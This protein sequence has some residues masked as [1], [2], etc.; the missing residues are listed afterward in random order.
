MFRKGMQ[1]TFQAGGQELVGSYVGPAT[2][3]PRV[4]YT[5]IKGYTVQVGGEAHQITVTQ[6]VAVNGMVTDQLRLLRGF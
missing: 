3:R 4:G 1:I 2:I 5:P 6:I